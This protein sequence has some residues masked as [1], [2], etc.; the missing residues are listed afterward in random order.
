MGDAAR[1]FGSGAFQGL[2]DVAAEHELAAEDLH[3]LA[4]RG[5][6]HRLAQPIHRALQ[7]RAH[8]A[9]AG[10]GRIEHFAGQHQREG[11]RVDECRG[12][13]AQML[14][15]VDRADLVADQRIGGGGIGH[16]QQRF[17]EA[18]QRDAFIGVEPVLLKER[19]DPAGLL[20]ARAFDQI[21]RERRRLSMDPRGRGR[22]FEPLG[23]A[24][25]FLLPIGMAQVSA[26]DAGSGGVVCHLVSPETI[27]GNARPSERHE[28]A[29]QARCLQHRAALCLDWRAGGG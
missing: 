9:L 23:D 1:A 2:V 27:R 29:L 28:A 22:L 11:R 5:A 14:A 21:D 4:G 16:T 18:H 26:V 20:A 19:V 24:G 6:D 17:G 10:I 12:A 8:A 3:R 15:P 7:H 13:F 25:L